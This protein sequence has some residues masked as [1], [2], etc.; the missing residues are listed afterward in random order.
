MGYD[1]VISKAFYLVIGMACGLF[2]RLRNL[3]IVIKGG[4]LLICMF[5]IYFSKSR[6]NTYKFVNT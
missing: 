3:Q 4:F 2:F 1:H 5:D 6:S